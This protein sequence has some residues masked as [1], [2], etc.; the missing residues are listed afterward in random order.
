MH[1]VNRIIQPAIT[2]FFCILWAATT[3]VP[4]L[5]AATIPLCYHDRECI[6]FIKLFSCNLGFI[7]LRFLLVRITFFCKM[8]EPL[9]LIT[10]LLTLV[11]L[12]PFTSKVSLTTMFVCSCFH[13]FNKSNSLN[14]GTLFHQNPEN[15]FCSSWA[16]FL[17][18]YCPSHWNELA[19]RSAPF[20]CRYSSLLSFAHGPQEN[21]AAPICSSS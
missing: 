3:A 2:Q 14:F 6:L 19:K 4:Q 20:P 15:S 21:F 8:T 9:K 10:L 18:I 5:F 13:P 7:P 11:K 17:L 16:I 1:M 12:L